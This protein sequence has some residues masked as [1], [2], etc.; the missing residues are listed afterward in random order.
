M[1]RPGTR[2]G[3]PTGSAEGAGADA[4]QMGLELG[5]GHL[6]RVEIGG[7]RR[8]EQEPGALLA[9]DRGRLRAPVDGEVVEDDHVALAQGGGE[10]GLD[11][12]V[13]GGAVD[14]AVEHPGRHQAVVAQA[15]DEGLGARVAERGVIAHPLAAPAR[16]R[17][18]VMLV[19]VPHSSTKTSR[20]GSCAHARL[21]PA[22]PLRR[23]P[24]GRPRARAP[25]RGATFFVCHAGPGQHPRDRRGMRLA[26]R[27][28]SQQRRGQLLEPDVGHR[29]DDLDQEAHVGRELAPPGR[30]A[31]ACAAPASPRAACSP[32]SAPRVL[33]LIREVLAPRA[34]R[35]PG[36][37]DS[38]R[39]PLPK[40]ERIRSAHDP[41]PITVNHNR[42][43]LGIPFDSTSRTTL[44]ASRRRAALT[45]PV[46]DDFVATGKPTGNLRET[47]TDC[48]RLTPQ[49]QHLAPTGSPLQSAWPRSRS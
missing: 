46:P 2:G 41:P 36:L 7:V 1:H 24:R 10:L 48:S 30:R 37:D 19:L 34:R 42:V 27:A 6:D 18:R 45:F 43:H 25:R 14:R 3:T 44:N 5:E 21:A 16:P 33:T 4:A 47:D 20:C 35:D 13:E 9:Q 11:P 8:Q 28:R 17:A 40:I 29:L 12:G 22:D 31:P 49:F 15:G 38:P 23:A 26:P 39:H 32:R